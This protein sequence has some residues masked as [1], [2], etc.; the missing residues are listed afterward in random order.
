M[1]DYVL[2]DGI[3]ELD[4]DL[5]EEHLVQKEKLQLRQKKHKRVMIYKW[6]AAAACL[7]LVLSIS[8]PLAINRGGKNFGD[9]GNYQVSLSEVVVTKGNGITEADA[10]AFLQAHEEEILKLVSQGEDIAVEDL[11]LSYYGVYHVTLTTEEN[12]INEDMLTYYVLTGDGKIVSTVELYRSAGK[13]IYQLSG[14]GIVTETINAVLAQ[15]PDAD[16]AMIY[17]DAF[18]EAMVAPDNTVYFLNGEKPVPEELEYYSMFNLE[19][20]ILSLGLLG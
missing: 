7:A 2:I 20:N 15:H 1:K 14:S 11:R 10:T 18:T 3:S 17:I 6:T 16:F 13:L 9:M 8:I 5:L 4:N 12:F 19:K